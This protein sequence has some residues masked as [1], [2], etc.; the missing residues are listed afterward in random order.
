MTR[1]SRDADEVS[2]QLDANPAEGNRDH[3]HGRAGRFS[4]QETY[5][6]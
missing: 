1:A 5:A 4:V 3:E 2:R 6:F